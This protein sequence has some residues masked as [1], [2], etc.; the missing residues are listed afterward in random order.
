[1]SEGLRSG[2]LI[3]QYRASR[4]IGPDSFSMINSFT[5]GD[6]QDGSVYPAALPLRHHQV[7]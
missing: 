6:R 1:M 4:I 7:P 2:I 5:G 3:G